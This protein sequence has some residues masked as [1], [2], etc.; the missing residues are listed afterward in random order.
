MKK[1][2]RRIWLSYCRFRVKLWMSKVYVWTCIQM[3]VAGDFDNYEKLKTEFRKK[4]PIDEHVKTLRHYAAIY[5]KY[6]D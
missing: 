3:G 5:G 1:L 2:K 4:K 6:F